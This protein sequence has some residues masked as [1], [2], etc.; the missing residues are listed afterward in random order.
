[1]ETDRPLVET[2]LLVSERG[3]AVT[4]LNWTGAPIA[5]LRVAVTTPFAVESVESVRHGRLEFTSEAGR[6]SVSLPL[7]G[8]DVLL[9]RP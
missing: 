2:P 8:A 3:A 5:A 9:L 1:V 4:L 7:G 6:V